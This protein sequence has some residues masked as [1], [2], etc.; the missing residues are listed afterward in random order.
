MPPVM[1]VVAFIMAEMLQVPYAR[2]CY[3][4]FVPAVLY[5][6]M[7]FLQIDFDAARNNR[8]GITAQ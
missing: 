3:V 6:T 7:L 2:I 8:V 1:G 4:A 5:Y